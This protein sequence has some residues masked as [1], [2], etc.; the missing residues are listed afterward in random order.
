VK[1][2]CRYMDGGRVCFWAGFDVQQAIPYGTAEE[3]RAEVRRLFD[4]FGRSDGRLMLTMGNGAT[5]DWPVPSLE[6]LFD[7]A[8]KHGTAI[9]RKFRAGG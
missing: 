1:T 2:V 6:A 4:I 9:A 5:P 8:L 3:V 7:E